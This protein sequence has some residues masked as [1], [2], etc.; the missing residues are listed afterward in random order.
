LRHTA[1]VLLNRILAHGSF[2]HVQVL[3][4]LAELG[5]VQRTADAIG[6][7]QPSVS[8]ALASL[9]RLLEVQLFH[10]H[11]RGVRPT[12]A[13]LDL[14][15]VARQMFLG[16]AETAEVVAARRGEAGGVVR[17]IASASAMNGLL[18]EALPAF[19][20]VM[21]KAQVQT[22]EGEADD[23]LLAIARGEVDIVVCRRPG[24]LPEGWHFEEL[25]PDRLA[26]ICHPGHRLAQRRRLGWD[27]VKRETWLLAP[28]GSLARQ[29]FDA[30]TS[31]IA[32]GP[33]THPVVTRGLTLMLRLL[34]TD[35]LLGFVPHSFVRHLL[36]SEELAELP[37]PDIPAVPGMGVLVPDAGMRDAP[38][39]LLRF[40][41]EAVAG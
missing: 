1:S 9:E 12:P 37:L 19:C 14:L 23:L 28:A 2:R 15:P 33:R 29:A 4:R 7:T 39:A 3:L 36:A 22:R 20:R 6:M 32:G 10:R 30:L 27:D 8:Q 41:R 16:A 34:E 38:D 17:L 25:A 31:R 18:L 5:S 40:L 24:V 13:C 35:G 11:A 26:V 21:P